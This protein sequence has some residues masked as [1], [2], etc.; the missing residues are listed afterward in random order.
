MLNAFCLSY[1]GINDNEILEQELES[2][3]KEGYRD[4]HSSSTDKNLFYHNLG[5]LEDKFKENH[6]P[7]K[8]TEQMQDW[9]TECELEIHNDWLNNFKKSYTN[10]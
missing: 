9:A 5:K 6:I 7:R 3:Y 1:L 4:F 8:I 2:S 10:E